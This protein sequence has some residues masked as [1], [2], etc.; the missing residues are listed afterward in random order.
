MEPI[1]LQLGPI[2]PEPFYEFGAHGQGFHYNPPV[3]TVG[4]SH[5]ERDFRAG[6]HLQDLDSGM[7]SPGVIVNQRPLQQAPDSRLKHDSEEAGMS[8]SFV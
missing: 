3:H 4:W 1:A 6:Y 7:K 5:P 8:S 2:I